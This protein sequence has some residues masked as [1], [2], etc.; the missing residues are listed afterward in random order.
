MKAHIG[1]GIKR[2]SGFMHLDARSAVH[3]D[4]VGNRPLLMSGVLRIPLPPVVLHY[5]IPP[6]KALLIDVL[7]ALE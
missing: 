7:R 5:V 3:P 1:C 4:V 6:L 2:L